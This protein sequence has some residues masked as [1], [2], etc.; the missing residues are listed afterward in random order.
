MIRHVILSGSFLEI[1]VKK[2][3]TALS[4]KSDQAW[5]RELVVY[6]LVVVDSTTFLFFVGGGDRLS[7]RL[8]DSPDIAKA[9]CRDYHTAGAVM[10]DGS[11]H[12][13]VGQVA[14]K[15]ILV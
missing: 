3:E 11:M 14:A 1:G 12:A 9:C 5:S 10:Q 6:L 2:L 13:E 15:A 8:E 7:I 4:N